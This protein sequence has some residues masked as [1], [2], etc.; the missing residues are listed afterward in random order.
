MVPHMCG[1]WPVARRISSIIVSASR[2]RPGEA[3]PSRYARTSGPMDEL[4]QLPA[5]DGSGDDL[6]VQS[7]GWRYRFA[8]TFDRLDLTP[9][10]F[11]QISGWE[12]KPEGA[13]RGDVCVPL[14]PLDL[15][16]DGRFDVTL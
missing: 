3:I 11:E 1:S 14:P 5:R 4:C 6:A 8:M 15:D 9:D 13:C 12:I 2:R 7:H 10:E 16:D